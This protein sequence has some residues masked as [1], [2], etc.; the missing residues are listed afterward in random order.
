MIHKAGSAK[1]RFVRAGAARV[2]LKLSAGARR[3][4]ARAGRHGTQIEIGVR[5]RLGG[6][7]TS[8]GQRTFRLRGR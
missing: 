4:I 5:L 7:Q 6:G 3:A 1:G 2:R 8:V